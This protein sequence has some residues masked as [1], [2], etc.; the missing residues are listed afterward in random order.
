MAVRSEDGG[1]CERAVVWLGMFLTG[2]VLAPH[3]RAAQ[4]ERRVWGGLVGRPA[5]T[6]RAGRPVGADPELA[7]ASREARPI[8]LLDHRH[9]QR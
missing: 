9:A 3:G 8:N 7:P 1:G 5:N 2:S 4:H 6:H